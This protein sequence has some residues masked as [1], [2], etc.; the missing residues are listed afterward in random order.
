[1]QPTNVSSDGHLHLHSAH[2]KPPYPLGVYS[3][4]V[5]VGDKHQLLQISMHLN[6]S[7]W[8]YVLLI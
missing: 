3:D 7:S 4:Q 8:K 2:Q 5:S 1:M 6:A